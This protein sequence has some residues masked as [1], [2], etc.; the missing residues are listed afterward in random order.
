MPDPEP[1]AKSEPVPPGTKTMEAKSSELIANVMVSNMLT[2]AEEQKLA[3]TLNIKAL[4][5]ELTQQKADQADVYYYLNKKCDDSFEVISSLEEQLLTEQADREVAEKL[6]E[7]RIEALTQQLEVQGQE[8][9]AKIGKLEKELAGLQVF[10]AKKGEMEKE[11]ATLKRSLE[12]ER[13]K[14]KSAI[15]EM[16]QQWTLE[17]NRLKRAS[18]KALQ[19]LQD[20]IDKGL[21]ARLDKISRETME[22]NEHV[23]QELRVQSHEA[24]K[25]LEYNQAVLDKEKEL[26]L[27]LSLSQSIEAELMEKMTV[28][29]RTIKTQNEVIG[30]HEEEVASYVRATEEAK[31]ALAE[32]V[33]TREVE[34]SKF[35]E[36]WS[37]LLE[38]FDL[39][40]VSSL[41]EGGGVRGEKEQLSSQSLSRDKEEAFLKMIRE[42]LLKFP[43]LRGLLGESYDGLKKDTSPQKAPAQQSQSVSAGISLFPAVSPPGKT[44]QQGGKGRRADKL[45]SFV[46]SI[47][48]QT[49]ESFLSNVLHEDSLWLTDTKHQAAGPA[50]SRFSMGQNESVASY[51]SGAGLGAGGSTSI[52]QLSVKSTSAVPPAHHSK[53]SRGAGRTRMQAVSTASVSPATATSSKSIPIDMRYLNNHKNTR[54]SR[55]SDASSFPGITGRKKPI[56]VSESPHASPE[57]ARDR[58]VEFEM[59]SGGSPQSSVSMSP[60][61]TRDENEDGS[62]IFSV[63]PRFNDEDEDEMLAV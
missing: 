9:G 45:F 52:D 35:N 2:A 23:E 29:Q 24:D 20:E 13:A 33:R 63:S 7:K 25:V 17:R 59:A 43:E 12:R 14:C 56:M 16:E 40:G 38:Q 10:A 11:I 4:K 53:K 5:E 8:M 22:R 37:F 60:R 30:R 36:L 32:H 55:V 62:T 51:N 48:T 54:Q 58:G 41:A 28:Y 39:L 49:D 27:S 42:V 46:A 31:E 50:L 6:Y 1:E 21:S 34:I 26:R 57:A 47:S 15:T 61:A 18:D 44:G 19:D 3:L